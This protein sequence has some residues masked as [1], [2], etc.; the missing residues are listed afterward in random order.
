MAITGYFIDNDWEYREV[1]LG[2]EPL[3]GSHTGSNLSS[4]VI[5]IFRE[6]QITDQV[7]SIT[8]DNTTNNNTMINSIQEEIKVE[9]IGGTEVFPVPCLAH[10]IQLSLNQL[11]GKMKA[12][13]INNKIEI[14][15]SDKHAYSI[16][17]KHTNREIVD[18]LNKVSLP[19]SL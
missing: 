18:T 4:V 11:L 15:W 2:F 19:S 3:Y 6:H 5:N 9:G 16:H 1:L 17:H 8:T 7:L 14:K 13:P 10:V 12:V